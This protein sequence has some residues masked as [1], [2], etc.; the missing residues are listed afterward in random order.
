MYVCMCI[1]SCYFQIVE[2]AIQLDLH[3]AL[4]ILFRYARRHA[5]KPL[6]SA[7]VAEV[8]S[9]KD[10]RPSSGMVAAAVLAAL[11]AFLAAPTGKVV[12]YLF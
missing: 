11:S 8:P 9:S 3:N 2:L 5:V 7:A 6:S 12:P 10:W 4:N 1:Y